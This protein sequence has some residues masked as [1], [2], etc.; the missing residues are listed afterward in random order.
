MLSHLKMIFVSMIYDLGTCYNY[1]K[2]TV[3]FE[4]FLSYSMVSNTFYAN[5]QPAGLLL[6]YCQ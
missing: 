2:V 3:R 4:T 5:G 1:V 6:V